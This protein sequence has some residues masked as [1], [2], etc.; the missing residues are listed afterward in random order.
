MRE[1]LRRHF[2]DRLR[3]HVFDMVPLRRV[4]GG[5]HARF[6]AHPVREP[7]PKIQHGADHALQLV[8]HAHTRQI[9][10]IHAPL[11]VRAGPEQDLIAHGV[12]KR[13]SPVL[14]PE[15]P[16]GI[17]GAQLDIRKAVF[18]F[19]FHDPNGR[20]VAQTGGK[21]CFVP[22]GFSSGAD[23]AGKRFPVPVLRRKRKRNGRRQRG[24]NIVDARFH[25][26]ISKRR[27]SRKKRSDHHK[28]R[29]RIVRRPV[30]LIRGRAVDMIIAVVF[31]LQNTQIKRRCAFHHRQNGIIQ[32]GLIPGIPPVAIHLHGDLRPRRAVVGIIVGASAEAIRHVVIESA[33]RLFYPFCVQAGDIQPRAAHVIIILRQFPVP[34][35]AKRRIQMLHVVMEIIIPWNKVVISAPEAAGEMRRICPAALAVHIVKIEIPDVFDI[36]VRQRNKGAAPKRFP[37]GLMLFIQGV[38]AA[39]DGGEQP[40]S[41]AFF[42]LQA[43]RA[44]GDRIVKRKPLLR[45]FL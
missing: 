43:I 10:R 1:G 34:G 37:C 11:H 40:L 35:G 16:G 4:K 27:I 14:E 6:A 33:L 25:R 39:A 18:R 20:A 13:R 29:Q 24:K 15:D 41:A 21:H 28:V 30:S 31:F 26:S 32:E 38:C 42:C 44:E 36:I 3:F 9:H 2:G 22:I 45:I 19:F 8:C 12:K 23:A 5:N 17:E 7:L